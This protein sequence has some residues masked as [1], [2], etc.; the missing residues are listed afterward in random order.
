MVRAITTGSV[1]MKIEA[2]TDS[3]STFSYL[4]VAHLKLPAEKGTYY[5]LAYLREELTTSRVRSVNWI[6]TRDMITDGLAKGSVDRTMLASIM[7][8]SFE[9][10]YAVHEYQEPTAGGTTGTGG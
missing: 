4:A 2:I 8:G 3:Y 5:H 9:L 10:K 1:P 7:S 6:D